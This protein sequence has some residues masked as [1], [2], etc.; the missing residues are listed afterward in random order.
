MRLGPSICTIKCRGL[1]VSNA[2]HGRA[3]FRD[4]L[5]SVAG[6]G[7]GALVVTIE[8]DTNAEGAHAPLRRAT[9]LQNAVRILSILNAAAEAFEPSL[10][11][12]DVVGVFRSEARLQALDFWMRNPDYLAN[13]LLNEFER[14]R[15]EELFQKARQILDSREPDLRRFPMIRFRFGAFEPLDDALSLLRSHDFIRIHRQGIPGQH[16][17]EHTYLLTVAGR[18]A[19]RGLAT[20]GPEMQWYQQRSELVARIAGEAGGRALKGRQY[21]QAEYAETELGA[22]IN[23]ITE[24][25]RARIAVMEATV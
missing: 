24:K 18:E 21:L 20:L 17:R 1:S 13:E 2:A 23:S 16:V 10:L 19:M 9:R 14:T 4:M 6:F 25:V 5:A 3:H 22:I 12:P 11:E 8:G 7:K 15:E